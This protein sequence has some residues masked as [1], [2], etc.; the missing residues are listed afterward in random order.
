MYIGTSEGV[1]PLAS[2]PPNGARS[3]P[4]ALDKVWKIVAHL[5]P[6][7]R[8]VLIP[9]TRR[10]P[11]DPLDIFIIAADAPHANAWT[12]LDLDAYSGNVLSFTPYAR[13]A[14]GRRSTTSGCRC[15]PGKSAGSRAN[16]ASSSA[17]SA[18]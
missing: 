10:A 3:K 2:V 4:L 1:A 9:L 16:S 7:P 13:A 5:S 12:Y 11:T 6:S 18:R 15:I 17:P 8:E 14:S